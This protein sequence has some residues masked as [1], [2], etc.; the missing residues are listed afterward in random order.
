MWNGDKDGHPA[1][2]VC[3]VTEADVAAAIGFARKADLEI[4]VAAAAL[5]G[6]PSWTTGWLMRKA[7]LSLDN[8]VSVRVVTADGRVLLH[9]VG[10]TISSPPVPAF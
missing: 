8:L 1:V 9:V 5:P 4:A 10:P 6:S 3:C 7:G 2:I